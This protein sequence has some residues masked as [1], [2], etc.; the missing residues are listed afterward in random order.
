MTTVAP[1]VVT[2]TLITMHVTT[3]TG[4]ACPPLAV[5]GIKVTWSANDGVASELSLVASGDDWTGEFPAQP[6]GTLINYS[7]DVV[8]ADGSLVT[9][10]NNPADPRYQVFVGEGRPIWCEMFDADP[11]WEE[12][13]GPTGH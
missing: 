10:P 13:A 11:G 4:T 8:F 12:I 5:S 1:P 6:E 7:V 9:Y 2:G 3:P